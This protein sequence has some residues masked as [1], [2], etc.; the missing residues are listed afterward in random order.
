MNNMSLNFQGFH[1]SVFTEKYLKLMLYKL[2]EESP[3]NAFLTAHFNRSKSHFKGFVQVMYN[4]MDLIGSAEGTRLKDV[5]RVII[6]Q[7]RRKLIKQRKQRTNKQGLKSFI[8]THQALQEQEEL[9]TAVQ[10]M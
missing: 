1:P 5:T 7:I 6:L 9:Q 3:K 10:E 2:V 8:Q 4:G